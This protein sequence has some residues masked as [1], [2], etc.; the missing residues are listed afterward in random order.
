M[1]LKLDEILVNP[2]RDLKRNPLD[3][4]TVYRLKRSINSTGFWDNIVIRKNAEGKYEQAYGHHRVEAAR[5]AGIKEADFIVKKLTDQQMI[6]V[7]H[8]DNDEAYRF[9]VASLFE[10]VRAVVHALALGKLGGPKIAK[11]ARKSILRY[12]PSFVPGREPSGESPLRPYTAE[13]VASHLDELDDSGKPSK[14]VRAVI[15]ALHLIEIGQLNEKS[16]LSLPLDSVNGG[17]IQIVQA[18]FG[19]L[20]E[21]SKHA[22][23]IKAQVEREHNTKTTI[24][25]QQIENTQKR[26]TKVKAEETKEIKK[27]TLEEPPISYA[28]KL[29]ESKEK[30]KKNS[31]IIQVEGPKVNAALAAKATLDPAEVAKNNAANLLRQRIDAMVKARLDLLAISNKEV[32]VKELE[33]LQRT[34]I[35]TTQRMRIRNA[36]AEVSS[37]FDE[38]SQ[39]FIGKPPRQS[40]KDMLAEQYK[41]EESKRRQTNDHFS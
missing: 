5:Q 37:F 35:D 4:R 1:R 28:E 21:E 19:R 12:A 13:F 23:V 36:L 29:R 15:N 2:Y 27:P 22:A 34:V 3:P 38:Q 14:S 26:A 40:A 25:Q 20:I 30:A 24:A 6:Q 9:R 10:S 39:R 8:D 11:D 17:L 16:L 31:A 33:Y 7:L 32:L 41:K 18:T